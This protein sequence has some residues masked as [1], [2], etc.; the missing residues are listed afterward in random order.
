M[1]AFELDGKWLTHAL[2]LLAEVNGRG[3]NTN[4]CFLSFF[5]CQRLTERDGFRIPYSDSPHM[6]LH[7][8]KK[9]RLEPNYF[10]PMAGKPPSFPKQST[11]VDVK[12]GLNSH[13][14]GK[15][16]R[17]SALPIVDPSGNLTTTT[18]SFNLRSFFQ[19]TW[20]FSAVEL[21]WLELV[22]SCFVLYVL[23]NCFFG[24][25]YYWACYMCNA[26]VFLSDAF[27]FSIMTLISN[28][29]YAGE[30]TNMLTAG[31]VCYQFRTTLILIESFCGVCMMAT[32][33][34]IVVG[35][36][37]RTSVLRHRIVFSEIATLTSVP[38]AK[39]RGS[40]GRS[41]V[42]PLNS[43]GFRFTFRIA[44][45]ASRPL[46]EPKL[47]VFL[48]YRQFV[49]DSQDG[50]TLHHQE[51]EWQ[52]EEEEPS[53]ERKGS[54][55]LWVP[56]TI[57]IQINSE[58]PLAKFVDNVDQLAEN[59]PQVVAVLTAVDGTSGSTFQARHC[60]RLEDV[61]EHYHFLST[62]ATSK[63][64]KISVDLAWLNKVMPD[65]AMSLADPCSEDA[66]QEMQTLPKGC[67][68]S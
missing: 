39:Y 41:P 34:A 53:P 43:S 49:D 64:G 59:Q 55:L 28:G 13:P 11:S 51:L 42:A 61:V 66:D 48:N 44:Q 38:L 26:K 37:S 16:K 40:S 30:D 4:P 15:E 46:I 9:D 5:L 23:V 8:S 68:L 22:R 56:V 33:V 7:H 32:L 31:T 52:C 45:T 14:D 67:Q 10:T 25:I 60:Y 47:S 62:L 35:H 65:T 12:L 18:H 17:L 36:A 54:L 50:I 27:Y 29:G 3:A 20:Y 19:L 57:S 58:S 24:S 63:S 1:C 2:P 21:P 6:V